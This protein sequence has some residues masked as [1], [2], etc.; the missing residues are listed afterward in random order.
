MCFFD[1]NDSPSGDLE[2]V[3]TVKN[4]LEDIKETKSSLDFSYKEM[5]DKKASSCACLI[6]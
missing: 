5:K 3:K 4:S 6:I 2:R 1:E